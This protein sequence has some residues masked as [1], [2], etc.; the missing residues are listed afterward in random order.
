MIRITEGDQN[1]TEQR[2]QW[3]AALPH[4]KI[5]ERDTDLYFHQVLS[6]PCLD[7]I[8]RAEGAEITT[9]SGRTLL[10]FHGNSVHQIGFGH[11][12]V[13]RAIERQMRSLPYCTRRYTNRV[14]VELAE[15]LV[16]LAPGSL[17]A[18]A[19]VLLTPSGSAAVGLALK[20]AFAVTGRYRTIA[21]NDAFHGATLD[22]ASLSGQDLFHRGMGPM[23]PGVCHVPPLTEPGSVEQIEQLLDAGDIA[24]VMAEPIRATCVRLA[25]PSLWERVRTACDRNG[26][27]LIL[28]EIPTGLGRSGKLWASEHTGITPDI[29]V[30]GKGL[31]GGMIPQAAVIGRAEFN[32]S[33]TTPVRELALGHYTHEK[34]PIGCAAAIATLDIIENESLVER[35][36]ELGGWWLDAYRVPL[37]KI[38]GVNEVRQI[39]LMLAVELDDPHHADRAMYESLHSGLSFKVGAAKSLVLFPPLNVD[40]TQLERASETLLAAIERTHPSTQVRS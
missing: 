21:F 18:N 39:G 37:L 30:I 4:N 11:P 23:L 6:T 12:E 7:E 38:P 17:R 14:A 27:L 22:A 20:L 32:D 15:R 13:I 25:S 19:R 29:M 24:A 40:T 5:V 26:T 36:R 1:L 8:V 33:G 35:S 16:S 28:D 3:S 9:A 10:D 31:G 34:S 2:A